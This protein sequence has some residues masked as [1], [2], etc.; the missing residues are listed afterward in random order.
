[1]S[2][3]APEVPTWTPPPW[4][5]ATMK[6][7]LR[8]P[9]VQRV[10]GRAIA[11]LSFT[12]RRSGTRYTTPIT[13]LRDGDE[14]LLITKRVR[15][16]WKNLQDEPAVRLRLAGEEVAG[17][18]SLAVGDPAALPDLVRFLQHHQRDAK[19]Y[20]ITITDGVV[21]EDGA[22]AVLPQ[23]VIITVTLT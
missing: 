5:N 14:V 11:L 4:L 22:R 15:T 12:G 17:R 20:N 10:V 1:M 6:L 7:M 19:A 13:Y 9:G 8:T 23:L 16:W 2:T 3:D 18:A 21:D